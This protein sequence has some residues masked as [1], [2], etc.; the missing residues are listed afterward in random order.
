MSPIALPPLDFRYCVITAVRPAQMGADCEVPPPTTVSPLSTIFT[1]VNG[2]ATAEMS[3]VNRLPVLRLP[4]TC[5]AATRCHGGMP[6]SDDTPPPVPWDSGTSNQACSASH[7][8]WASV[9]RVVP[10]TLVISGREEMESSPTS[11]GPGGESQSSPPLHSEPG[12]V[13]AG[14]ECRGAVRMG[15]GERGANRRQIRCG[16]QFVAAPADRETPDRAG[17]LAIGV[18][19]HLADLLEGAVALDGRTG[20][21]DDRLGV[22]RNRMCDFEI[23]RGLAVWLGSLVTDDGRGEL[24]QPVQW[25]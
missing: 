6:K 7:R 8:P 20:V 9:D 4:G 3:G 2:S 22:G 13:A 25:W 16:E 24:G 12:E 11:A 23:H 5:P 15:G 14:V 17:E 18:L 19:Q 1:P 21:D 10:P